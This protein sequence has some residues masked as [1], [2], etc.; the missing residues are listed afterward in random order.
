VSSDGRVKR[1]VST[2]RERVDAARAAVEARRPHIRSVDATFAAMERDRERA[3]W[4]LAGALAHR[5]FLWLLPFTL[6]LVAGL[7]FLESANHD[8]P[9]DLADSVGV[10]GLASESISRAAADAEHA[11][12][13]A[14]FVGVP[15]L[16]LASI[17]A[18]KAFRT[19]SALIW[20]VPNDRIPR[21]PLAALSLLGL[22]AAFFAVM[23]VGSTVRHRSPGPGVVATVLVGIGC[24]WIAYVTMWVLPRP[25]VPWTA[26]LPGSFLV[27]LGLQVIH[28][29]TVYFISY[30]VS[31]SSETYGA[32]GV[33]AALLL[34]LYLIG[35]LFV[36]GVILNATLWEHQNASNTEATEGQ[37]PNPGDET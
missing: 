33:A 2:G 24:V 26:L 5:L 6:V 15:T 17:G 21:K 4:L 30:K 20:G 29:T 28:L 18:I 1:L 27:G 37:S 34:S 10:V 14:L 11:R 22:V 16:Y 9:S 36:A 12:F 35:R 19:V 7:G 13:V 25:A 23:L 8:S 31:S 32:L 3:G